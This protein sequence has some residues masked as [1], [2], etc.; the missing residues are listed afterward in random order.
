MWTSEDMPDQT[1]RTVIITG[2]SSGIGLEASRAFAQRGA[3]VV[4]AVRNPERGRQAAE[5]ITGQTEVRELNLADLDSVRRFAQDWHEPVDVLINNAGVMAV[6]LA[7]S[8]QGFELQLATNHLGHF[9]LT[10]LLLPKISDRIVT[11]S[12]GAHRMKGAFDLGDLNWER[13]AYK[14]WQAYAQ[15]KV[16]NLLFTL[17]LQRRLAA[18]HSAVRALAAHLGYAA[19]NLQTGNVVAGRTGAWVDRAAKVGNRFFAQTAAMGSLPT[20]YAATQDLPGGSYVGPDGR[21]E[22]RGYPTLVGRT[23][24]A[25]DPE[26]ARQLWTVSEALTGVSYPSLV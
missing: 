3:R 9:A 24:E 25:S 22:Q 13:R 21:R 11:V 23:A 17:E 7:R 20:L 6:P 14:P 19:T 1:G 18:D 5:R 16:A 12:S 26:L 4:L 10:N 8:P 2:A 15:T